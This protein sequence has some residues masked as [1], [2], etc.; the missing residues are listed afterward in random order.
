LQQRSLSWFLRRLALPLGDL[1]LRQRMMQR[2]QFLE[3][4]QWWPAERVEEH[5]NKL[6]SKVIQISGTEVPFY[7]A[8]WDSRGAA[9][10]DIARAEDLT[11][12]PVTTKS[13]MRPAYPHATTRNTGQKTYEACSSGSTGANFCVQEDA[14]TAGWYRASFFL[15]LQWAGWQFGESHVQT[16]IT[17]LRSPE[18]KMKD[19]LL[20]CHYVPAFDLS[21]TSLDATL[22]LM[23]RRAIRHLWGYPGGLHLLA[24]RA[25][26][27]GWNRPLASVVTWGDNLYQHYRQS[28]EQAF[29]TRVFDTYGCSEGMQIAAQCGHGDHYHIHSLDVVAEFVDES[30][31]P[32]PAGEPGNIVLTRL[33]PGPT[34][35]IRYAIGDVGIAPQAKK[36][37]CGRGFELM[38]SIQGRD[39]DIVVTPTGNRIIVHAFAG[40]LEF[41]PELQCFQ[42][43]QKERDLL[44]VRVVM[45]EG[46]AF[47]RDLE[48][49]I[50]LS[51]A[52]KGISDMRIVIEPVAD[53]PATKSGKR[54]FVISEL[55]RVFG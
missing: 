21:D 49:R 34:P 40:V 44:F 46:H 28:M 8:L 26:A 36:C 13:M 47:S 43:V 35:L 45:E 3:Q 55:P 31:N 24:E 23:D 6:L 14:E 51:L 11:R 9:W 22:E 18:K 30:G 52:E 48:R 29:S 38:R 4:A 33:H 19:L 12:L 41:F 53:I 10:R 1:V 25:K 20:Q 54:R 42:V 37:P 2:L 50:I 17:S 7:R 15:A 16:G 5:R 39:T 32:V 27:K